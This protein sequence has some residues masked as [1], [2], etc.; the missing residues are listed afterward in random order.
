MP[1]RSIPVMAPFLCAAIAWP[2]FA[3]E[4]PAPRPVAA[5]VDTLAGGLM[6]RSEC[7]G[8]A[9]G[10]DHGGMQSFYA[11]GEVERGSGRRPEPTTEFQIGSITKVFTATLL[12]LYADRHVVKLDAPLQNYVPRGIAVPSFAGRPITLVDLATHTSGLPR[13]PMLRGDSYSSAPGRGRAN[14]G[15]C[16]SSSNSLRSLFNSPWFQARKRIRSVTVEYRAPANCP[17]AGVGAQILATL[18]GQAH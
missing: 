15:L 4:R 18:N 14:R 12:A 11:Y 13:Q 3:Q 2:A 8:V 5:V 9:V 7:V 16:N 17:V 10:V 1:R 6:A